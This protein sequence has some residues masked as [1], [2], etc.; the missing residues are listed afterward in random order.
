MHFPRI[1]RSGLLA[2]AVCAC[3]AE[4]IQAATLK[5][6]WKLDEGSGTQALDSSGNG[7]TGTI[8]GAVWKQRGNGYILQFDGT[9]TFVNCGNPAAL[10]LTGPL[11][12]SVWVRPDLVPSPYPAEPLIAGRNM[13]TNYAM[14][15]YVDGISYGYIGGGGNNVQSNALTLREWS[16]LVM[17]YDGTYMRLYR[18]GAQIGVD[19]LS[20]STPQSNSN[21]FY[22]GKRTDVAKYF[23]GV[24]AD[25]KVY[26]GALTIGEVQSE[27]NT[28]T[29]GR[30]QP[31]GDDSL[32]AHY[33]LNEGSGTAAH[34]ATNPSGEDDGVLSEA[35]WVQYGSNQFLMFDGIDTKVD[36]PSGPWLSLTG[37][38]SVS[39]WVWS[40]QPPGYEAGIA[41][42]HPNSYLLSAYAFDR[43]DYFYIGSGTNH[44]NGAPL[45]GGWSHMVGIFDG[46]YLRMYVNGTALTP[47]LSSVG[48]VPAG[49]DFWI[50]YNPGLTYGNYF[51]GMISDVKVWKRAITEGDVLADYN[52]GIAGRY[53]PLSVTC[54]DVTGNYVSISKTDA[55]G[56]LSARIGNDAGQ[57]GVIEVFVPGTSAHFLLES[58]FSYPGGGP[59]FRNA[60]SHLTYTKESAWSPVATQLAADRAKITAQGSCFSVERTITLASSGRID[61]SDVFT[62]LGGVNA[63]GVLTESTV[64]AQAAFT[65]SRLG[66]GQCDP[67]IFGAQPAYDIGL[68]ANDR[69]SR[70]QF[71]PSLDG[72]LLRSRMYH[73][74]LSPSGSQ[75]LNY[76]L[77]PYVPLTAYK[78]DPLNFVNMARAGLGSNCTIQGPAEF[79][80]ATG[81]IVTDPVALKD[82]LKRMGTKIVLLNPWLDY[83]PGSSLT[84]IQTRAQ[85]QA[86]VQPAYAAV[87]A[88]D[89]TVKVI[90]CMETD[91]VNMDADAIDPNYDPNDPDHHLPRWTGGASSW[92]W[93][94]AA[95]TQLII[96]YHTAHPGALPWLDSDKW[97][98][99][100]DK[101]GNMAWEVYH[102]GGP[103]LY[104]LCV[105]PATGNYQKDFMLNQAS[106]IVDTCGL[107]GYYTDQFNLAN[108][109]SYKKLDSGNNTVSDWDGVS[110]N[111]DPGN[112]QILA[113][114]G[115]YVDCSVAGVDARGAIIDYSIS[116]PNRIH[117]GNSYASSSE[118]NG[119]RSFRFTETEG[120][121]YADTLP[122]A[123]MKP[124]FMPILGTSQ[125]GTPIAFGAT[126]PSGGSATAAQLMGCVR[127]FLRHSMVYYHYW[128]PAIP[129]PGQPGG[130]GYGPIINM[131]PIT[132]V[133]LFEGGI[134]GQERIITC[135]SNPP[136]GTGSFTWSNSQMPNVQVFDTN[137]MP[138]MGNLFVITPSGGGWSVHLTLAD[139]SDIAV[140]SG[141]GE[142]QT[143][144]V[145]V[146]STP[147]AGAA[148]TGT[149]A[150]TTNYSAGFNPGTPVSFTA[151]AQFT[152]SG[153]TDYQFTNWLLRRDANI[154]TRYRLDDGGASTTAADSSG[155]GHTGS[156]SGGGSWVSDG[157]HTVL[158]LDGVNDIVNCG[159]GGIFD[160][161]TGPFTLSAWVKPAVLPPPQVD[162]GIA[163]KD[164]AY[165]QLSYYHDGNCYFYVDWGNGGGCVGTPMPVNTWTHVV[166]TFDGT[167]VSI[168]L[169]GGTPVVAACGQST[170]PIGGSFVIG[171]CT[172]GYFNGKIAD[173]RLFNRALSP[174]EA[175]TLYTLGMD[176]PVLTETQPNGQQTVTFTVNEP[177]TAEAAYQVVQR[178]LTVNSTPVAGVAIT[179]TSAGTTDYT[180]AVN[181]N[182]AVSLSALTTFSEC[183]VDYSFLYWQLNG[184]NQPNGQTTLAFTIQ[185]DS[186]AAAVYNDVPAVTIT[187]PSAGQTYNAPVTLTAT[188]S[189]TV[190]TISKVEFFEG[191]TQIG[192]DLTSSPYTYNW[193]NPATG[194]HTIV[195]KATD[196]YNAVGTSSGVA[197]TV[198][199]VPGVSL[200]VSPGSPQAAPVT[201]TLTA[202]V[203]NTYGTISQVQFFNNGML[204]GTDITSPY[205]ISWS[206]VEASGSNGLSLTAKATDSYSAVG[207]SNTVSY[208][209]NDSALK[210]YWKFDDQT[211][212]SGGTAADSAGNS[213]TG[214]VTGASWQTGGNA[215]V[216]N[217]LSF[218]GSSNY[219]QKTSATGLPAA[220]ATQTLGLWVYIPATYPTIK[221]TALAVTGS[222][223]ATNIGLAKIGSTMYFGVWRYDG[224]LLVSTTT[225]PTGGVWHYVAYVKNGST[226][227]LYID[228]NAA[229]TSTI[230]TDGSTSRTVI[231]AGRT[232]SGADYWPGKLDEVRIYSRVL[233]QAEIQGLYN[234][235]SPRQ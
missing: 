22:I 65:S 45:S 213:N 68:L 169:N 230:A 86:I 182:S 4:L 40:D 88:A 2:L 61:V 174:T 208:T 71:M 128:F 1:V 114:N 227:Y 129:L 89:P 30:F 153:G 191:S 123:G 55:N 186:T 172:N 60:F 204:I 225:L 125:I 90:G 140:I 170:I 141:G 110:V 223:V 69:I 11:S 220:N 17:V 111:I 81:P 59:S 181:D 101:D 167:N 175:Q 131:F 224:T 211:S 19:H 98:V 53:A 46:T 12:L 194:S 35:N 27:Y 9:G 134:I 228:N 3:S 166:A 133:R 156:L 185:A 79:L 104:S 145:A 215:R 83:D 219:V 18:N 99:V 84:T 106:F 56:T 216:I 147:A 5:A 118:E 76:S 7:L 74:A 200:V 50:G 115:K 113:T 70:S 34:D 105:Y 42:K 192:P 207:T 184:V 15:Y 120:N 157:G 150:G 6:Y 231:N 155:W 41:G 29:A 149:V 97:S 73:F 187:A 142:Q 77:Y 183:G 36:C 217:C 177:V 135:V 93:L 24:I 107:D 26:S 57:K 108:S 162:S 173:V 66:L 21:P 126:G 28:G 165:F 124:D 158:S 49:G 82:H 160:S 116:N 16:H 152:A 179:G 44:I 144:P 121:V 96:D 176:G 91:W 171:K 168:R 127:T 233:T 180:A 214:T 193:T 154:V 218:N 146:Q 212:G 64:T 37:P 102:R 199:D 32:V 78:G 202:T 137:G 130:G 151:P 195:A 161:T 85:Y 31:Q 138:K 48:N 23:Q 14:T 13:F 20:T 139:W 232:A 94:N 63:V 148:V 235:G 226:N 164:Y 95:Q 80:D 203:T 209:V 92:G 119:R 87:K 205:S 112:G 117:V 234:S 62:N 103:G 67:F 43:T 54:P 72:N 221:K 25:V 189:D 229:I 190:G 10:D 38:L 197:F 122:P 178:Q 52:A 109:Q 206:S 39:A 143:C 33:P 222:G 188:V 159:S 196:S 75:T 198:N 132:P 201:L 100:R 136:D 8:T 47:V 163:G 58:D 210:C 51:N